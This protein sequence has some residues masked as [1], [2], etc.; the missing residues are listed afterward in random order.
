VGNV[1]LKNDEHR[2]SRRAS[3]PSQVARSTILALGV[4]AAC[5]SSKTD[6]DKPR[7]PIDAPAAAPPPALDANTTPD[8]TP[9]CV[10]G[11]PF[12]E[13]P[14]RARLSY[15]ASKELAGRASGSPGEAAA[16]AH[17]AAAFRCLGLVPAGEHGDYIQPF[18]DEDRHSG[19]VIGYL[20]G[21][22]PTVGDE[23]IVIGAHMDHVGQKG[24][25]IWYGA[26]DNGSGTTAMLAIA[27][28]FAQRP[29]PRRTIAFVGFGSEETGLNGSQAFADN[30]PEALP[31]DHVVYMINLD[32]V[33]TYTST[34]RVKAY[35]AFPGTHARDVLTT[36]HADY[37]GLDVRFAGHSERSDDAPFCDQ[38]IPYIFLF[39]DDKQCYHRPCDTAD[40]IDYAD[41]AAIAT[42]AGDL[43]HRLADD[44][45]DLA[46]DRAR[47]GCGRKR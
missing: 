33:G 40:R 22:D 8:A 31:L 29:A 18:D 23:I 20:A 35:G 4:L 2:G 38:R 46:A 41:L 21:T 17:V 16:R 6:S 36:M 42:M 30:P 47:I 3:F 10:A 39:T 37:P 34:K 7:S 5:G 1:L 15:L 28:W 45:E 11:D 43:A 25:T 13:A 12:A 26:N 9:S 14:L 32:M 19:N 27:Q 44:T 24:D